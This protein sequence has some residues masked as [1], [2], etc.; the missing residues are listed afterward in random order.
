MND[1]ESLG[2]PIAEGGTAL[3]YIWK[4]GRVFKLF[5]PWVSPQSIEREY[6]IMPSRREGFF[7]PKTF[8]ALPLTQSS[9]AR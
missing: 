4:D 1:P 3:I 5:R 6:Q 2:A 9:W 8:L 7:L